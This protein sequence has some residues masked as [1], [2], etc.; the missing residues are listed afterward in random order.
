MSENQEKTTKR[1]QFSVLDVQ[2][3]LACVKKHSD[4]LE[5]K[6]TSKITPDMKRKVKIFF[7]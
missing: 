7:S 3:L 2:L 1:V 6:T 4:V 5:N